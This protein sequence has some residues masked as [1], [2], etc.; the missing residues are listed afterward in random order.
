[1]RG[2]ERTDEGDGVVAG[3]AGERLDVGTVRVLAKLPRVRLSLPAPRSI[4]PL[5]IAAPRVTVSAPP[6]PVMVSVLE[7]SRCRYRWPRPGVA[8]GAEVDRAVA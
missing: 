7:L 3:A 5:L 2:G 4:V 1:M 6:P 8:A